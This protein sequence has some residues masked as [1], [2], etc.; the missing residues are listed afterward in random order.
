MKNK[1]HH[2]SQFQ[3]NLVKR[4]LLLQKTTIINIKKQIDLLWETLEYQL[5]MIDTRIKR[6]NG[7]N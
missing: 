3:R 4:E 1:L 6:V 5:D 2:D 7:E